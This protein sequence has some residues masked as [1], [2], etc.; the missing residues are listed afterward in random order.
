MFSKELIQ[1]M[2]V[3][4]SILP[5]KKGSL[6]IRYFSINKKIKHKIKS[7]QKRNQESILFYCLLKGYNQVIHAPIKTTNFQKSCVAIA[8][9]LFTCLLQR[10]LTMDMSNF[11]SAHLVGKNQQSQQS[12]TP[13]HLL[14]I[15]TE[16]PTFSSLKST[17][18]MHVVYFTIF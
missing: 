17:P 11:N 3:F 16:E 7:L 9:F 6:A 5:T 1:L 15:K 13:M 18:Q 4:I 10:Y 12:N 8:S 2:G 14:Q